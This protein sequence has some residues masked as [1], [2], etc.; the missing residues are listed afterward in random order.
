MAA[1]GQ[2]AVLTLRQLFRD[3]PRPP[4]GGTAYVCENAAVLLAAADHLGSEA[5]GPGLI[6]DLACGGGRSA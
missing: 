2:L 6:A 5:P 1:A 4:G 3:A